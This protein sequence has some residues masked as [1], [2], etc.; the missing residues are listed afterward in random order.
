VSVLLVALAALPHAEDGVLEAISA[1]DDEL[2][3]TVDLVPKL[4][5][6]VPAKRR[7]SSASVSTRMR[8][9]RHGRGD[10]SPHISL[11]CTRK[12]GRGKD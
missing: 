2:V 6:A 9:G 5:V 4:K 1:T 7:D 10:L 3:A 11:I 12:G 8:G